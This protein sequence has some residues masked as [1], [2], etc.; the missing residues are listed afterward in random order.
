M[1]CN[2]FP[3]EIIILF[4]FCYFLNFSCFQSDTREVTLNLPPTPNKM[5]MSNDPIRY[6]TV[7]IKKNNNKRNKK[8]LKSNLSGSV[9]IKNYKRKLNSINLFPHSLVITTN[10]YD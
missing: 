8:R 1:P 9:Q 10:N 3:L 6:D 4:V 2:L 7:S 5:I